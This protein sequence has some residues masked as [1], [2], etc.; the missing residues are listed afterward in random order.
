[1]LPRCIP[2][3]ARSDLD[4]QAGRRS[5]R[6]DSPWGATPPQYLKKVERRHEVEE[7]NVFH[8]FEC[9]RLIRIQAGCEVL[10]TLHC[11]FP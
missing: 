11:F 6:V 10:Q 9:I 5:G 1:M 2:N 8:I 4:V 3:T 7:K